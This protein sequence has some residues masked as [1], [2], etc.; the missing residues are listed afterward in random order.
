[1]LDF[2]TPISIWVRNIFRCFLR[3]VDFSI[4]INYYFYQFSGGSRIGR[5]LARISTN[6]IACISEIRVD[7]I[8][9]TVRLKLRHRALFRIA[10]SKAPV[11]GCSARLLY[12]PC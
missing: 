9:L 12:M 1:V 6:A 3:A 4:F 8:S 11:V 7:V 5:W 2:Y 10:D